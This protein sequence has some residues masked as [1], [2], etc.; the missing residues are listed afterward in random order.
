MCVLIVSMECEA[1]AGQR[2]QHYVRL[3]NQKIE[4]L[5][6]AIF[7]VLGI[8]WST[9]KT[10]SICW[11]HFFPNCIYPNLIS[12]RSLF[13]T[14]SYKDETNLAQSQFRCQFRHSGY[15][16]WLNC[17]YKMDVAFTFTESLD[18]YLLFFSR[19]FPFTPAKIESTIQSKSTTFS[20]GIVE[21]MKAIRTM[22][23]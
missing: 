16:F 23:L 15:H 2:M 18:L 21:F 3:Q 11:L 5:L 8:L 14:K 12:V 22:N 13:A 1:N 6:M 19:S 4:R 10:K 17:V 7:I 9:Q 20:D